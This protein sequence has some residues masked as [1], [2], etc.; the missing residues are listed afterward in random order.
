MEITFCIINAQTQTVRNENYGSTTERL[1]Q[2][3]IPQ[4]ALLSSLL[5]FASFPS[6]G[7]ASM[8]INDQPL[9][10]ILLLSAKYT[11]IC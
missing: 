2:S 9:I 8:G 6:S 3:D 11:S 5:Q 7:I 4:N 10:R 1:Q